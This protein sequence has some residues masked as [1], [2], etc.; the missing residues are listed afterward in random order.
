MPIT[1]KL[2]GPV[3]VTLLL[4]LSYA[5][6]SQDSIQFL[7]P[8]KLGEQLNFKS[9]RSKSDY[10]RD[11]LYATTTFVYDVTL[12][13][14]QVT[15]KES[16]IELTYSAN[17]KDYQEFKKSSAKDIVGNAVASFG[18]QLYGFKSLRVLYTIDETGAFKKLKNGSA[19]KEYISST[20]NAFQQDPK[21]SSDFKGVLKQFAPAFLSDDYI[22]Y[23]FLMEVL[24]F[25]QAYGVKWVPGKQTQD[26]EMPNPINGEPLPGTLTTAL[27]K[28]QPDAPDGVTVYDLVMQQQVDSDKMTQTVKGAVTDAYQKIDKPDNGIPTIESSLT[29]RYKIA[30]D[31]V[32]KLQ[33][34]KRVASGGSRST[35]QYILE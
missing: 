31:L 23:S 33:L 28:E 5:A 12:Q 34:T 24:A 29:Y 17:A 11:T 21:V 9:S 10:T 2:K 7:H 19:L 14:K 4:F 25:H 22:L 1:S 15:P 35:E 13:V 27:K 16:L 8:W 3:L 6:T 32:Q 26:I 30:G 18:R 20:L